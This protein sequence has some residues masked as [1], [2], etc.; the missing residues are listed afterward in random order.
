M[1]DQQISIVLPAPDGSD[2]STVSVLIE[3]DANGEYIVPAVLAGALGLNSRTRSTF[4][5]ERTTARK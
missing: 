3:T 1:A 4:N 5:C 2:T